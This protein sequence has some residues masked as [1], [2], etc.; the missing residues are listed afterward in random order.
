MVAKTINLPNVRK[1]FIPEP[2]YIICESDL[3]R[4]DAQVVAWEACDEK[5]KALFRTGKDIHTS[6]GI[7]IFGPDVCDWD[8]EVDRYIWRHAAKTGVHAV[9]YGVMARTLSKELT[10]QTGK[11][12]TIKDAQKFIDDWFRAHPEIKQWHDRTLMELQ[13]TRTVKNKFGFRR[14]YFDRMNEMLLKEA[15]AWIPQST[16]A[17]VINK[18]IVNLRRS[19]PF[20]K[21]RR[22]LQVHD[23]L[24]Y[25]IPKIDFG[26]DIL[27]EIKKCLTIEIPY[28]DP[29]I[30]PVSLA[31]SEKS[32]GDCAPM[33]W[34]V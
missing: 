15:L 7:D 12:Y 33:D 1:F 16:V 3:E 11:T 22:S 26:P 6:N 8:D 32:W 9:N 17:I 28:D 25:Q 24:I 23:S 31:V 10:S 2:G 19:F 13:T 14:Y 29:L 4:A 30:I 20:I 34:P 5:L 21:V 27:R 18:G